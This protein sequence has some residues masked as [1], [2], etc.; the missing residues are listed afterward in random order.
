M[1][2]LLIIFL[3][4]TV[5]LFPQKLT[6]SAPTRLD[7]YHYYTDDL[8]LEIT[9]LDD[10]GDGFDFTGYTGTFNLKRDE[11]TSAAL[12][13]FSVSFS[14]SI[15]VIDIDTDSLTF[16]RAP[17][18]V[19]YTLLLTHSGAPKTW[20]AGKFE[21]SVRPGDSQISSLTLAYSTTDLSLTIY[22]VSTF[23]DI[24]SDSLNWV[25]DTTQAAFDSLEQRTIAHDTLKTDVIQNAADI[26]AL[27]D[28]TDE[29]RNIIDSLVAE[30]YQYAMVHQQSYLPWFDGMF[31]PGSLASGG[32]ST[33]ENLRLAFS[34]D[35]TRD[36][37]DVGVVFDPVWNLRDPSIIQV[38]DTFFVACTRN[39]FSGPGYGYFTII[40]SADLFNWVEVANISCAWISENGAN[41]VNAVWGPKWFRDETKDSI[42]LIVS[43]AY[44]DG[45]FQM[46]AMRALNNNMNSFANGQQLVITDKPSAM[47]GNVII[48]DNQYYIFYKNEGCP[49]NK[50]YEMAVGNSLYG[51]YTVY[52]DGNWKPEW[53]YDIES[54]EIKKFGSV[55]RLYF[56]KYFYKNPFVDTNNVGRGYAES[57]DLINWSQIYDLNIH[58]G[59][60]SVVKLNNPSLFS[61]KRKPVKSSYVEVG[62]DAYNY[63]LTA[64]GLRAAIK[65]IDSGVV[66]IHY[67]GITD[68]A[69]LGPVP[70]DITILGHYLNNFVRIGGSIFSFVS[71]HPEWDLYVG[72]HN[73][74]LDE[75]NLTFVQMRSTDVPAWRTWDDNMAMIRSQAGN[76]NGLNITTAGPHDIIFSYN[77]FLEAARFKGTTG[78]F[79]LQNNLLANGYISSPTIDTI[80]NILAPQW[81]GT[82]TGLNAATGRN[83]L[84]GTTVGG[85][86]FTL[87]NPS[88]ISFLRLNADN[89]VT[90]RSASDFKTD[91]SLNNVENTALSTWAG[92][93]SITTLGTI[94][95]GTWNA[96][97]IT[98]S[99]AVQGT[100]GRFTNL[101]DGFI[102]YHISDAAGLGNSGISWNNST[103]QAEINSGAANIGL[104]MRSSDGFSGISLNDNATTDVSR[105]VLYAEGNDMVLY[106]GASER[107]RI[108]SDGNVGI[109]I[110]SPAAT[111][112][113]YST[114]ATKGIRIDGTSTGRLLEGFI[115]GDEKFYVANNGD[116]YFSVGAEAGKI[117]NA[118]S[119]GLA[120]SGRTT[121]GDLF[122]SP[123]GGIGIGTSDLDGTP[124]VGR[125][126]IKASNNDGTSNIIVGR[127]SGEENKFR[128][129]DRGTVYLSG[130]FYPHMTNSTN[131]YTPQPYDHRIYLDESAGGGDVFLPA[132]VDGWELTFT[133][134]DASANAI[135]LYPDGSE[136]IVGEASYA[137]SARYQTITMQYNAATTT[138]YILSSYTKP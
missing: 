46:Y 57:Y 105:V 55:Y 77:N 45:P 26:A 79:H 47:D 65:S 30:N 75:N 14:D 114:G 106:A 100:S 43:I 38:G 131:G 71:P 29:H 12:K 74:V 112:H 9:V 67:P 80:K 41:G 116:F 11:S 87:P 95:S 61:L 135:T 123:T 83:S 15:I 96:G 99:G 90:A 91:L 107:A 7:L 22:G 24:L 49:G 10:N 120:L 6:T 115:N 56:D 125:V 18:L 35:G 64:A 70:D 2:N 102:P 72:V 124:A 126:T 39:A 17:K 93:S 1:K 54:F 66:Y 108:K 109:G 119:G 36:W 23:K 81:S 130:G 98:S 76:F 127:N 97:A 62:G 113:T 111:L 13:S 25:R 40:K 33:M 133:K 92:S 85:N 50:C 136:T 78:N 3:L 134:T 52:H 20:L 21:Y 121:S 94:A 128:V 37:I 42:Y 73:K 132:G 129:S 104:I 31:G 84:G 60:S 53:G 32:D 16:L 5:Y 27:E 110:S 68:T 86:L 88:A 48:K 137:I 4:F 28:T 122:L 51:P 44:D 58:T 19:Y 63:A 82:S 89:T 103:L 8:H 101:T 138:W 34:K 69:G 59:P 117:Y 118:G